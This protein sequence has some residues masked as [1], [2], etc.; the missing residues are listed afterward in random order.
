MVIVE[1]FTHRDWN[2]NA[3][4]PSLIHRLVIL[5]VICTSRPSAEEQPPEKP[6]EEKPKKEVAEEEVE[7]EEEEEDEE[8]GERE[9]ER[10][11]EKE[12][13]GEEWVQ[14]KEIV[15]GPGGQWG[16]LLGGGI[17]RPPSFLPPSAGAGASSTSREAAWKLP[18][19]A[20]NWTF[21]EI[22]NHGRRKKKIKKKN[23]TTDA[24]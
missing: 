10:E 7:E 1:G 11:K 8:E 19:L 24:N 9:R 21:S 23:K 20:Q 22:E 6:V 2:K 17:M 15:L 4:L 12:K 5:P 3:N 13:E 18:S 16:R 14:E